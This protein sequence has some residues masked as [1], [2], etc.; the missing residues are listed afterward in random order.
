[1]SGNS[2]W[3]CRWMQS[4]KVSLIT[5]PIDN[6][7]YRLRHT[8][9]RRISLELKRN[10][11]PLLNWWR[12]E[13][14][15]SI[16]FHIIAI[17]FHHSIIQS[18]V[19][20]WYFQLSKIYTI[21]REYK[22]LIFSSFSSCLSLSLS[23]FVFFENSTNSYSE[24]VAIPILSKNIWSEITLQWIFRERERDRE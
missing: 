1:M 20:Q 11:V 3:E 6:Y 10:P 18:T 23:I 12:R 21:R 5:W 16:W 19:T 8:E 24:H 14:E 7:R 9:T 22:N 15:L 17:F 2:S 13:I 4:F